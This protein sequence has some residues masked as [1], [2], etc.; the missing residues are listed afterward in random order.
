M[1][2]NLDPDGDAL[3]YGRGKMALRCAVTKAMKMPLSERVLVTIYRDEQ[4][5]ILDASEIEELPE[6]PEFLDE[7]NRD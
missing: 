2:P 7:D 4:P 3:L 6:L 1:N 5:S